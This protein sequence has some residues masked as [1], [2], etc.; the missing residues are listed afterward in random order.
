MDKIK[1]NSKYVNNIT[2]IE[3]NNPPVNAL[4]TCFLDDLSKALDKIP[5][6][7]KVVVFKSLVKGFSAGA[8]LKE[9]AYMDDESAINT[10][11]DI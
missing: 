5:V 1:I 7:A 11:S 3:M 10:V 4:S 2:F 8:D 9:R 6:D